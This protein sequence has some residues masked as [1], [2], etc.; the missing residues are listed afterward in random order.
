[1]ASTAMTAESLQQIVQTIFQLPGCIINRLNLSLENHWKC[2]VSEKKKTVLNYTNCLVK[3]V[4]QIENMVHAFV[5]HVCPMPHHFMVV[6][7]GLCNM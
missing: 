3:S 5:H 2:A 1:M 4:K 7:C 6:D